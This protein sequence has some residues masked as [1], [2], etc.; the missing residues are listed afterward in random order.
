ML[1]LM[2]V[3][4]CEC[5]CERRLL[6][7]HQQRQQRCCR[8]LSL[9][10]CASSG[11]LVRSLLCRRRGCGSVSR[12]ETSAGTRGTRHRRESCC[13]ESTRTASPSLAA[14]P[15]TRSPHSLVARE[16]RSLAT[17]DGLSRRLCSA[18]VCLLARHQP[19]SSLD[20]HHQRSTSAAARVAAAVARRRTAGTSTGSQQQIASSSGNSGGG[21]SSGGAFSSTHVRALACSHHPLL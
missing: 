3:Y 16:G 17:V 9:S 11:S 8:S 7:S 14:A 20:S 15:L 6:C 10:A 12:D 18:T 19:F 4:V 5:V 21:G 1:L 2:S 13:S